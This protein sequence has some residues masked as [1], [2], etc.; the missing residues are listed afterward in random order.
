ML[1]VGDTVNVYQMPFTREKYEGLA[2]IVKALVNFTHAKN[3][4]F[5]RAVVVFNE[6]DH[7]VDRWVELPAGQTQISCD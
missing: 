1:R 3:V 6:E 5:Q 4:R 7:E 2:K